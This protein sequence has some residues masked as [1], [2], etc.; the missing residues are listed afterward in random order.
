M[1][2]SSRSAYAG[3]GWVGL[4]A[5]HSRRPE[6]GLHPGHRCFGK[7]R[8][9][10]APACPTCEGLLVQADRAGEG[11]QPTPVLRS[12]SRFVGTKEWGAV[13]LPVTLMGHRA[14][15][16]RGFGAPPN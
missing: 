1:H 14:P 10:W 5:R 16:A 9:R 2:G 11:S 6:M 3:D 13:T 8:T 7:H 15:R 12:A 4:P